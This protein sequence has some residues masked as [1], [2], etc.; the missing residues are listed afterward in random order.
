MVTDQIYIVA[1]ATPAHDHPP[2]SR[3]TRCKSAIM[4]FSIQVRGNLVHLKLYVM[5]VDLQG[6]LCASN[7][8][9]LDT[10]PQ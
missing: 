7:S 8:P 2:I 6:C 1:N 3:Y 5:I 4:V 9:V 10:L